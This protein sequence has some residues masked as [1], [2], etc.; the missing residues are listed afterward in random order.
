MFNSSYLY[1]RYLSDA[2]KLEV[3]DKMVKQGFAY[4]GKPFQEMYDYAQQ[5]RL[6]DLLKSNVF[7]ISQKR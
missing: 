7:S 5:F 3:H 2:D 1:D 6:V 4:T